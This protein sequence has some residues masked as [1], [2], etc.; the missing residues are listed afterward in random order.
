MNKQWWLPMLFSVLSV[1]GLGVFLSG[2]TGADSTVNAWIDFPREGSLVVQ[3]ESQTVISHVFATQGI[4]EAVLYVNGEPLSVSSPADPVTDFSEFKYEWIPGS[5]G[6]QTLQ[7]IVYTSTGEEL[8]SAPVTVN[9]VRETLPIIPSIVISTTLGSPTV[10]VA[11]VETPPPTAT[12]VDTPGATGTPT[13]IIQFWAEPSTVDA[14]ECTA[15]RWHVENVK[16]VIFGGTEQSFD[17]SYKDCL[18]SNQTYTLT[19]MHFDSRQEQRKVDITVNGTCETPTPPDNTPPP[20]PVPMVPADQ[21][22][23]PCKAAQDL[24]WMPVSDPE[25]VA[26]YYVKLE[27]RPNPNTGWNMVNVWGLINDKQHTVDVS[28]GYYYRWGVQAE[29]GNGNTSNW[30]AWSEFAV[31]LE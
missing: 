10:P 31:T 18:C 14:G 20:V 5:E 30:S 29:D 27:R 9:V 8:K 17:G 16:T 12:L 7:L 6:L 22:V 13:P 3:G 28:C 21:L 4:A 26:G 2:C 15:I 11:T 19:I 24:V 1:Y 25:G 23:L